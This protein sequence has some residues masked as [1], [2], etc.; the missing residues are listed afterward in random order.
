MV[1]YQPCLMA[2]V[3]CFT[4]P[5]N[6]P[7]NGNEKFTKKG[8]HVAT[9]HCLCTVRAQTSPWWWS[10]KSLYGLHN[11]LVWDSPRLWC[12]PIRRC[13]WGSLNCVSCCVWR[14]WF[15]NT[16]ALE[17]HRE[18]GSTCSVPCEDVP[19]TPREKKKNITGMHLKALYTFGNCQWPVFP[20]GVSHRKHKITS[21]WKFELNRSSKLREND[22]RKNILGGQSCVLSHRN[23][24]N[25]RL[26]ARSLLLFK[27]EITSFSKTTLL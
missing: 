14:W 15:V 23:K 24:R 16:A 22:E 8:Q 26:L 25:K 11:R 13:H 1:D 3:L 6:V 2:K 21:L 5:L 7:N 19:D 18:S 12:H 20:L 10:C 27:W 9:Q 17:G 4:K